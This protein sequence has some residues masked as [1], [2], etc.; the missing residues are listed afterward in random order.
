MHGDSCSHPA[1]P[2]NATR[3]VPRGVHGTLAL[4]RRV[5]DAPLVQRRT[6]SR[7]SAAFGSQRL[8]IGL[9]ALAG[10]VASASQAEAVSQDALSE[11]VEASAAPLRQSR[12]VK[13]RRVDKKDKLRDAGVSSAAD[14]STALDAG[15]NLTD[16]AVDAGAGLAAVVDAAVPP[17]PTTLASATSLVSGTAPSTTRV[18]VRIRDTV[19][20]SLHLSDGGLSPEERARRANRAIERALGVSSAKTVRIEQREHRAIVF[21]ADQPVV[22]LTGEDAAIAGE[23][24]LELYSASVAARIA[25][26]LRA[27]ELRGQRAHTVFSIVASILAAVV[28][29]FLIKKIGDWSLR[30]R[31]WAERNPQRIPAIRFKSIEVVRSPVLHGA[32]LVT[33][34]VAKWF[35]Y[36]GTAYACLIF[37]LSRFDATRSYTDKLA[38]LVLSPLSTLTGRIA[39]LLPLTVIVALGAVVLWILLRFI[40]LF[41]GSVERGETRLEHMSPALAAPTSLVVRV[42]LVIVTLLIIAPALTGNADGTFAKL[43]QL[44]VAALLLASVPLLTTVLLGMRVLYSSRLAVGQWVSIGSVTGRVLELTLFETRIWVSGGVTA[45]VPHLLLL[46]QPLRAAAGHAHRL[47]LIVTNGPKLASAVEAATALVASVGPDA[48]VT[49]D[50][51]SSKRATLIV[52]VTVPESKDKNAL[53]FDLVRVL[54]E[55]GVSLADG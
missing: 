21:I 47:T 5:G 7:G 43:G 49:V 40:S 15:A 33:L 10:I 36:F 42:G 38:N 25:D 13:R 48:S 27:E 51:V 24:S 17:I 31:N 22:E 20:L 16:A 44:A 19:V 41:F 53:L 18:E 52:Q 11:P 37:I 8:G 45:R 26:I 29:F 28:G 3:H 30:A 54:G 6:S 1:R 46:W 32:A 34:A 9:L 4:P 35:G 2:A 50:S 55:N 14:A 12:I 39:T 23:G